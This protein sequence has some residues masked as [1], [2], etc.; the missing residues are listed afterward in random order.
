MTKR[1]WTA[2]FEALAEAFY[3]DTHYMAPGKSVPL[4]MCSESYDRERHEAWDAWI[5]K[6]RQPI[7]VEL[8][9]V[10]VRGWDQMMRRL[11]EVLT[12]CEASGTPE[13]E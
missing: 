3:R 5:A 10:E 2:E 8:P 6:R 1:N 11:G 9:P 4:E 7:R 12:Q 13:Q